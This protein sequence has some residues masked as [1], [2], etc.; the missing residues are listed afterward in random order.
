[1]IEFYLESTI[2][3]PRLIG[4]ALQLEALQTM[5]AEAS[6]R[7]GYCVLL[8][9]E[10]G[11]GKSRLV[12]EFRQE[13][14]NFGLVV[15]QG[16]CF[17]NDN[18]HPYAPLVDALRRFLGHRPWADVSDRLG[19]LATEVVKLLPELTLALPNLTPTPE[20]APELEKRRLFETL[21][22]FFLRLAA[23][24]PLL[25]IILERRNQPRIFTPVGPPSA[26]IALLSAVNHKTAG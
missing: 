13:A 21:I 12:R 25:L 22:Q 8:S 16:N 6:E 9:G 5:L 17:E 2:N 24:N 18:T 14:N 23:D 4:R 10:A 11:V 3:P 26:F 7:R 20:L 15:L 1:M 19:P